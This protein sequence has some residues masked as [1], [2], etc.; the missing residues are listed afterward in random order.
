MLAKN[1]TKSMIN[2]SRITAIEALKCFNCNSFDDPKCLH[3]DSNLLVTCGQ[4][5]TACAKYVQVNRGYIENVARVCANTL[6]DNNCAEDGICIYWC[7]HDSCLYDLICLI[8]EIENS[9]NRFPFS[10]YKGYLDPFNVYF[11]LNGRKKSQSNFCNFTLEFQIFY[12]ILNP[13]IK[14]NLIKR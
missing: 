1:K 5:Y 6:L 9:A 11:F 13:I 8:T 3:P 14:F 12:G 7:D 10:K 2:D 4:N